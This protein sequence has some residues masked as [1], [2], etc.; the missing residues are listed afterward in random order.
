MSATSSPHLNRSRTTVSFS[1]L[2]NN[3]SSFSE[4]APESGPVWRPGAWCPICHPRLSSSTWLTCGLATC[5]SSISSSGSSPLLCSYRQ[6]V[7]SSSP[8]RPVFSVS[9]SLFLCLQLIMASKLNPNVLYVTEPGESLRSPQA[10]SERTV[11]TVPSVV[12]LMLQKDTLI[13]Y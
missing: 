12:P 6:T 4:L 8:F 10:D 5:S 13:A 9:H 3:S 1:Q 7:S 2:V 11:S